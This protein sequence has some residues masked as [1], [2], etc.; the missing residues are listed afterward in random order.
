METEH[1]ETETEEKEERKGEEKPARGRI[2]WLLALAVVA[3]L[4]VGVFL[5][6]EYN[7]GR[8]ST[9]DAQVD[10]H[11][12]PVASKIYGTVSEVL[13]DDNQPVHSGDV[14][15]RI[16]TRD[17]AIKVEQAEAAMRLAES[18]LKAAG[19]GVSLTRETT[20][21]GTTNS[22]ASL[23]A[24][25]AEYLRAKL[26]YEL[27]TTSNLEV[28][29]AEVASRTAKNK[30]AQADVARMQPLM[31]K[32]EISKQQYD[33]YQETAL[34][35]ESDLKIAREN[36]DAAEKDAGIKH[37]AMVV[38]QA[39]VEQSRAEL[40]ESKANLRK[41][42]ISAADADSAEAAVAR[43]LAN[44]KEAQLQLS[45]T[46]IRAPEDGVITRKSV[47]VGQVVQAGQGLLTIV[48]LHKVWITANF[49]E[50]QMN[51]MRPG[52]KAEIE[53]DMYGT[54]IQGRV[55]SIAGATGT[56]LSLLPPENAT[57]NYVKIVQRIPV[58][59]E[60]ELNDEDL[61]LRPGMNVIA[62]VFTR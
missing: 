18:Q 40:K 57:G 32:E 54:T 47:E 42:D 43:A 41:S 19:M 61:I 6:I 49:K 10:G 62:T 30:K 31:E 45:Y 56:R 58:K 53:V 22:E 46:E 11:I 9:D 20:S 2:R 17:Y 3:V 33:A 7:S 25:E 26:D 14:I 29:R 21:S 39:R 34:V 44:L 36:L 55:D 8:V 16:D 35:A 59:I 4:I 28:A 48:P 50:T 51:D 13:V 52:Q 60:V 5:W 24:A 12:V 37:S 38:A 15:I 1:P 23:A 27:S